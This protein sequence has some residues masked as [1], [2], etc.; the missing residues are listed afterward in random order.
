MSVSESIFETIISSGAVRKFNKK[1][2]P[3]GILNKILEAGIWGVSILGLQPWYYICVSSGHVLKHISEVLKERSQFEHGGVDKIMAITSDAIKTTNVL[4]AVYNKENVQKRA[5]RL[6]VKYTEHAKIAELQAIGASVQNMI[7]M[8]TS[9]G[10]NC[11]WVNTPTYIENEVNEILNENKKL[12]SCLLLG[13][14]DL[15]PIRSKRASS[16]T[17]CRV[18]R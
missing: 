3:E 13:F 7:L 17:L 14:S 16:E 9:L 8:A 1:P 15:T 10:L 4:I 12:I 18:I 5:G 6:N 2:I 11:V